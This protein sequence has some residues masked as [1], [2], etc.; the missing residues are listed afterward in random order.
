MNHTR[1]FLVLSIAVWLF[2]QLVEG[3]AIT[4]PENLLGKSSTTLKKR[5]KRDSSEHDGPSEPFPLLDEGRPDYGRKGPTRFS[6]SAPLRFINPF[7]SD[8][9]EKK[10][11]QKVLHPTQWSAMSNTYIG[12]LKK[13]IVLR[14]KLIQLRYLLEL[15]KYVA[16]TQWEP[17]NVDKEQAHWMLAKA[18]ALEQV[19]ENK[20]DNIHIDSF[21]AG[22]L[23]GHRQGV[24]EVLAELSGMIENGKIRTSQSE[25]DLRAKAAQSGRKMSKSVSFNGITSI[26]SD[27]DG[28]RLVL[29]HFLLSKIR[30]EI[31]PSNKSGEQSPTVS[32]PTI[33]EIVE[34]PPMEAPPEGGRPSAVTSRR[35]TPAEKARAEYDALG[36]RF[37]DSDMLW[38]AKIQEGSS[39]PGS[40]KGLRKAKELANLRVPPN[41]ADLDS[42]SPIEKVGGKPSFLSSLI[43]RIKSRSPLSSN[44]GTADVQTGK[45]LPNMDI[46][47]RVGNILAARDWWSLGF[48]EGKEVVKVGEG[49]TLSTPMKPKEL[50]KVLQEFQ[51]KSKMGS[52]L[53][54][55]PS[56]VVDNAQEGEESSLIH[57]RKDQ[58]SNMTELGI[59]GEHEED[60]SHQSYHTPRSAFPEE[61][62]FKSAP[63]QDR[64]VFSLSPIG[65]SSSENDWTKFHF[66]SVGRSPIGV[67]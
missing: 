43:H 45:R 47:R 57:E 36:G 16:R 15:L 13:F 23:R 48:E 24:E 6:R 49:N 18:A 62:A 39:L 31:Y 22:F 56:G 65:K 55:G 4:S 29:N 54:P 46:K 7:K 2:C 59:E 32:S 5:G 20:E 14:A 8:S 3:A 1:R 34:E 38:R 28:P 67:H 21:T 52:S 12:L 35:E 9:A 51:G 33:S 64:S 19:I 58:I 10:S 53:D 50:R 11:N 60:E 63:A 61:T 42:P 17:A 30:N 26:D 44:R 27:N 25:Q 41:F 66:P 40:R 37:Q